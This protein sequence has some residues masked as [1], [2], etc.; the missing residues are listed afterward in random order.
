MATPAAQATKV[1]PQ[2]TIERFLLPPKKVP[3]IFLYGKDPHRPENSYYFWQKH[4]K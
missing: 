2:P 3:I 4:R 1:C